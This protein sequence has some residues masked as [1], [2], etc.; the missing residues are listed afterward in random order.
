MAHRQL[1]IKGVRPPL[2]ED[3]R[4]D[5]KKAKA[6]GLNLIQYR[7]LVALSK[8]GTDGLSYG[9]IEIKT[10]YY[11]VQSWNMRG[12]QPNRKGLV[13]QGLVHETVVDSWGRNCTFFHITAAG[14]KL[15]EK[16][17]TLEA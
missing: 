13:T 1:A 4:P 16:L 2:P 15:L 12:E 3:S 17:K 14:R 8:A 11:S 9:G 10:G 5:R 6:L 7:V